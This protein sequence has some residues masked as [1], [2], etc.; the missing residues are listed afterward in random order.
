MIPIYLFFWTIFQL[1]VV[2]EAAHLNL[3]HISI[4]M[5]QLVIIVT[6]LKGMSFTR[7]HVVTWNRNVFDEFFLEIRLCFAKDQIDVYFKDSKFQISV[8]GFHRLD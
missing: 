6:Y 3:D 1:S 2:T 7:L 4:P 5:F 8:S